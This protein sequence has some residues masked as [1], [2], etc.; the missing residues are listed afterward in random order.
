MKKIVLLAC[1]ALTATVAKAADPS[2]RFAGLSGWAQNVGK[3][4]ISISNGKMVLNVKGESETLEP[5]IIEDMRPTDGPLILD[6]GKG[7]TLKVTS[8]YSLTGD[9]QY[10]LNIG[11]V[12]DQDIKLSPVVYFNLK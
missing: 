5:T 9:V 8:G 6:L 4:Y 1:L 12:V 2:F 7:R 11:T 3:V 10:F